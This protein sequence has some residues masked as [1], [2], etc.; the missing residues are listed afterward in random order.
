MITWMQRHKKWLVI[1]IWISTIAFVG[2]GFV[3]WGNYSFGK[4]GGT[5]AVVGDREISIS[6]FQREYSSLYEQYARIFGEQ[7]N[8][9]MA[10]KLNLKD[11][12]YKMAIE[13][14]LILSYG[15]EL[16][17]TVTNEDI[18]KQLVKYKAFIKDGKF[19]KSTYEKVLSRNGTTIKE[20]ED[21]LKR[22]ILLEKIEKLFKITPSKTE[23]QALNQ[24]LFLKD[25][26]DIK[27]L[28]MDDISVKLDQSAI[29]KF[30]EKNKVN[31]LSDTTYNISY[32]FVDL[33]KGN[34][35]EEELRKYYEN[36]KTDFRKENDKIKSYEEAKDDVIKALDIKATKKFALKEYIK[37]KKDE[38]KFTKNLVAS[39]NELPYGENN[40]LIIKSKVGSLKKPFFFGDKYVIVK[41]DKINSPKVLTFDKA[42]AQATQD[43][44][45]NEKSLKLKALS[46][47]ELANF[48]GK[49]IGWVTKNLPVNIDGLSAVE[50]SQFVN[51]LF[52]Q[53]MK[54]GEIDLGSKVVLYKINDS[55]FA[56]YDEKK[57]KI[58]E[59]T[60]SD[61]QNS[62][63]MNNLIKRLENRYEIQSSLEKKE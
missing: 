55:K 42:Q 26:V 59:R 53:E 38:K 2:A 3:G 60:I 39:E 19:D 33:Q 1:T 29:K 17:L 34:Y 41:L 51:K 58:V 24:L 9:E 61:L 46:K 15:D 13:K 10:E 11:L 54:K 45:N 12:A 23:I 21:S 50:S 47:K 25:N 31:Y 4:K 37:Y 49:N 5:V 44:I 22:N 14:N 30:W 40:S 7:F 32:A 52:T 56:N 35:S 18:A 27:I 36:F 63:L 28:S 16:G 62:E 6:E 20:F 43:Y 48:N 8:K 57:D